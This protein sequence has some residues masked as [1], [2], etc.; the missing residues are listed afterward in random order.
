MQIKLIVEI[1]RLA[2]SVLTKVVYTHS[3]LLRNLLHERSNHVYISDLRV[4]EVVLHFVKI[5]F[6]QAFIGRVGRYISN[7]QLRTVSFEFHFWVEEHAIFGSVH[8]ESV[9]VFNTRNILL[10]IIKLV[11]V[12]QLV[13]CQLLNENR[14]NCLTGILSLTNSHLLVGVVLALLL[15]DNI[16]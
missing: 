14:L 11:K 1:V 9:Q 10:Q 15:I 2:K 4:I 7:I 6:R 13:Q 8:A 12:L 5:F 16:L 3:E